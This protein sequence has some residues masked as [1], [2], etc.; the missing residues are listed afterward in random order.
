MAA[1]LIVALSV[2]GAF[3]DDAVLFGIAYFAVRLLHVALYAV[4]TPETHDAVL[5]AAPGFLGGPALLVVAG[6]F[7][8]PLEAILG[9][10]TRNRLRYRVRSRC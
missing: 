4:A 7:D 8:G 1:M 9:R 10:G 3:G 5:R 6:F 2:P